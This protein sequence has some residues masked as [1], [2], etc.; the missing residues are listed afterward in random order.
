[1]NNI[2]TKPQ[3]GEPVFLRNLKIYPIRAEDKNG[4]SIATIEEKMAKNEIE[5]RELDDPE[6]NEII[7][8]NRGHEPVLM[9][10]GE[11]ITGAFQN[12]IIARSTIAHANKKSRIPVICAEEGRWDEIGGFRTGNYSYPTLR[13]LL[14]K[15]RQTRANVQK[16]IWQEIQRKITVTKTRS[17]TSS[18]HDI[19]ENLA[20]EVNRYIEGFQ[21]LNHGTIGLI[22]SAGGTILG[23]DIF[24]NSNIFRKT[25]KKLIKSYALDA[26][27]Y[28]KK[29][30]DPP[31]IEDFFKKIIVAVDKKR[32][33]TTN[34]HLTIKGDGL[35]GQ[36]LVYQDKIIHL[37][38][39]PT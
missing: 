38:A 18:M 39:F 28:Q 7:L 15:G 36:S 2:F 5:I 20:D 12:R 35:L 30:S 3:L 33:R 25:Q 11:E 31:N 4:V 8:I 24:L 22:S 21:N 26:L 14:L 19:F 10:D 34:Q 37:S 9:I 32:P 16:K 29:S 13:S 1:M 17:A 23:C 27:E 6:I